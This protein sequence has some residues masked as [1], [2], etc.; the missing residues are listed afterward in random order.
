MVY[1]VARAHRSLPKYLR[2]WFVVPATVITITAAGLAFPLPPGPLCDEGMV[3]FME[4]GCDWGESNLFFFCKLGVLVCLNVVF[5]AAARRGISSRLAF[6]PHLLVLA[7]I[8]AR[9]LS[10]D[11]CDDYYSHPQGNFG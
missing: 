1:S 8:V 6:V 7:F 2:V 4:G 5:I 9:E 3:L 10:Y 11:G